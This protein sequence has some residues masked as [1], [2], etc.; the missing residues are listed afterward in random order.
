MVQNKQLALAECSV[1]TLYYY[2]CICIFMFMYI[3]IWFTWLDQGKGDLQTQIPG[4]PAQQPLRKTCH[5]HS[6]ASLSDARWLGL[7]ASIAA[8]SKFKYAWNKRANLPFSSSLCICWL[9]LRRETRVTSHSGAP[10]ALQRQCGSGGE[11]S[12]YGE[13]LCGLVI[14]AFATPLWGP[15]RSSR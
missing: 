4:L 14:T 9:R 15:H 3:R 13:C 2:V 11:D 10:S 12:I 6:V 7:C 8:R 5:A 1:E